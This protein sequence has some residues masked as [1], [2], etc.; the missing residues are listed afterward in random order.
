[1]LGNPL[2]AFCGLATCSMM[3]LIV[4]SAVR[5]S[6]FGWLIVFVEYFYVI[7]LGVFPLLVALSA[8]DAPP[9]LADY[10]SKNGEAAAATY[11]HIILYG[12]GALCGYFLGR[13]IAKK[14]SRRVVRIALA[15][16]INNYTW[17]YVICGLSILFSGIYIY[18]VGLESAVVNASLV[19]GGDLSGLVGSEQ[20]LFLKTLAMLGL[21][22]MVFVPFIIIDGVRIKSAFFIIVLVAIPIYILTVARVVFFDTFVLFAMLHLVLG[23]SKV[24]SRISS[25][26][27]VFLFMILVFLFG[28]EFVGVLSVY[29]FGGG[30]FIFVTK[31]ESVTSNFFGHFGHLVYSIDAGIRSFDS[32]GPLLSRD[33]LLSP[34]GFLP[35]FIY[36]EV[37]LDSLSY[38]LVHQGERLSCINTQ[39][40]VAADEC[41]IP[42]YFPGTSAYV[43]PMVG[44]FLFGF[45]RFW[46]YSVIEISWIRLKDHPERLWLPY[47]LLL[48]S[49]QVMLVIPN[50]ISFAVFVSTALLCLLMLRKILVGM[51]DSKWRSG[52]TIDS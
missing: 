12:L 41:S 7:G 52:V 19:R 18:V 11:V 16:R 38:Q 43:L 40:F 5:R 45:V 20:Y 3:A 27:V 10:E 32:H 21:F 34:L 4:I 17:F 8:I 36:T 15:N 47:V 37:G 29:L 1:M 44:G 31:D 46:I 9:L 26:V 28:K 48:I 6:S 23:R 49:N 13:P 39:Y 24:G 22:A 33:V 14:V 30:D 25:F 51:S 2:A 42:P 50:T 35:S